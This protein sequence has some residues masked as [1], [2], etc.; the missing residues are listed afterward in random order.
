[1]SASLGFCG[2][3]KRG[4]EHT[5]R[6]KEAEAFAAYETPFPQALL[7]YFGMNQRQLE[8]A[9]EA[10]GEESGLRVDLD[11]VA[12]EWHTTWADGVEIDLDKLPE[13]VV[14]LR[15]YQSW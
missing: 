7:T 15:I 12:T 6:V 8:E 1:M 2:L 14:T 10:Q 5:L 11:D 3:R 13:G 4:A 9:L